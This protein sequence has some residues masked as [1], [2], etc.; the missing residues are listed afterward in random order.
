MGLMTFMLGIIFVGCLWFFN[1]LR[2][3]SKY[4]V[5]WL[6]WIGLVLVMILLLF[7]VAWSISCLAE[8]GGEQASAMGLLIFGGI[9]LI[10]GILTRTVIV[11]E[12]PKSKKN[13]IE[14]S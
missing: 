8:V 4:N 1:V 5:T 10:L 12:I 11:K 14:I 7:T 6:G 13:S 3:S 9:A 2:K